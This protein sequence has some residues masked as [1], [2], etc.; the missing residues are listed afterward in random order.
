VRLYAISPSV[1]IATIMA[2]RQL[3]A[4]TQKPFYVEL[5]VDVPD[6][7]TP[8]F[9]GPSVSA[10]IQALYQQETLAQ[11]PGQ[12]GLFEGGLQSLH[13]VINIVGAN[14]FSQTVPLIFFA[15][16]DLVQPVSAIGQPLSDA[17]SSVPLLR[18]GINATRSLL[19]AD[20]AGTGSLPSVTTAILA[21]QVVD[22]STANNPEIRKLITTIQADTN[23]PIAYDVYPFQWA[24]RYFNK[25]HAYPNN[26]GVIA[27]AYP[28]NALYW[29]S[30]PGWTSGLPP[31]S[32]L[33]AKWTV[34]D[35]VTKADLMWSLQWMEDRVNW[36]WGQGGQAMQ[37]VAETGW[38]SAEPYTQTAVNQ[39]G[40]SYLKEVL[41]THADAQA[42]FNAV[43]AAQFE[44]GNAPVMYFE[45]YDEPVKEA[46]AYP[47]EFSEN[48]YGI[49][50]WSALPKFFTD[51][52]SHPLTQPFVVVVMAPADLQPNGVAQ[53]DTGKSATDSAYTYQVDSGT[54]SSVPWFWGTGGFS[55]GNA[56]NNSI[57]FMPNP[58]VLL[59]GGDILTI[60]SSDPGT[61]QPTTIQLQFTA[62]QPL[63]SDVQYYPTATPAQAGSTLTAPSFAFNAQGSAWQLY[64]SF[65]WLHGNSN[66]YQNTGTFVP[67]Y[68]DFWGSLTFD[69]WGRFPWYVN[70]WF[71]F[72]PPWEK[73]SF[74]LP[75]WSHG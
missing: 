66:N 8:T 1:E 56:L 13:Y 43:E 36:I 35:T 6:L 7:S 62:S 17:N 24:D 51:T 59:S 45:A 68:Q 29:D 33:P 4:A 72:S 3:A 34:A 65:P 63:A 42:Y 32:V 18:W 25:Q 54:V 26:S 48:H 74:Q 41:G 49:Y 12:P 2:A 46:N 10:R 16:E 55:N 60:T 52:V 38:A 23:A 11:P 70:Q 14:V 57:T 19:K 47:M 50:G 73:R 64:M 37:L 58:S 20:L 75:S 40:T 53:A 67:V 27:N 69:R 21:G 9:N 39:Q 22:V 28:P 30:S 61:Q 71:W 44:I 5:E 15:H 31:A